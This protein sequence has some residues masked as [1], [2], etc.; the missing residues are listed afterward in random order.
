M[1]S[2]EDIHIAMAGLTVL[3]YDNK[4]TDLQR[5]T[6]RLGMSLLSWV[7]DYPNNFDDTF[8]SMKKAYSSE[9]VEKCLAEAL[10]ETKDA[11][12]K[13]SEDGTHIE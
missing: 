6:A 11:M 8:K 10:K 1:K 7:M 4:I 2:K 3:S 5:T 12:T 9:F 13:A